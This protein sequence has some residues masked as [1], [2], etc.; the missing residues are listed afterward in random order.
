MMMCLDE[1]PPVREGWWRVLIPFSPLC[2]ACLLC[3]APPKQECGGCS[4]PQHWFM[5]VCVIPPC[6][7]CVS[8][9]VYRWY[10]ALCPQLGPS[11]SGLVWLWCDWG[12]LLQHRGQRLRYTRWCPLTLRC[13]S[14]LQPRHLS[15]WT[16]TKATCCWFYSWGLER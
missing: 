9:S 4:D 15:L 11:C 5:S 14:E 3:C 8:G 6:S 7:G 12:I 10:L 1:M 13:S 2:S 16:H